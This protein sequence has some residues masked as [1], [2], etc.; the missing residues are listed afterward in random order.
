MV[1]YRELIRCG[2][3]DYVIA[4]I[5]V[6]Q[7]IDSIGAIYEGPE[8]GLFSSAIAFIGAKGGV[9]SSTIAHNIS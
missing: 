1:L 8:K 6:L 2:V 7:I 3:S 5:S 9:G 4:P